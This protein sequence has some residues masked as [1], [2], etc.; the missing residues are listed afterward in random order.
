[1]RLE[2][3]KLKIRMIRLSCW[4]GADLRVDKEMG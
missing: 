4:G 2:W 3:R 1:M